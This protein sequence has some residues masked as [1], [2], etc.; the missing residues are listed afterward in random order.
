MHLIVALGNPSPDYD[1]TRHN[2]G[3][4]TVA[5]WL[6]QFPDRR[7]ITVPNFSGAAYRVSLTAP[8]TNQQREA[9]SSK[10]EAIVSPDL[11][12]FMN[13]SGI[14]VATV[15][16]FFKVTPE[17][18]VVV[19]DELALPLGRMRLD[20]NLSSAG[21]NGV[22]S[23]IDTLGSQDFIRL[24]I[25]VESR[26]NTSQPPGDVF[27]LQRFSNDEGGLL[28]PAMK[29]A[30]NALSALLTGGLERAMTEYNQRT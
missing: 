9:S 12:C 24:R 5:T 8:T 26:A 3:R 20:R 1:L 25:G 30:G 15:L 11:G 10:L 13:T 28:A 7:P 16:Q 27:V 2:V 22:Q 4:A 17:N 21:H 23:I 18:L 29:R 19:H 14:P 6:E